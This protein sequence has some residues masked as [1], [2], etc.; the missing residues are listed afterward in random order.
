MVA[1]SMKKPGEIGRHIVACHISYKIT[2]KFTN[3]RPNIPF[4]SIF[5]EYNAEMTIISAI[6]MNGLSFS[7]IRVTFAA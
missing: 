4:Q 1:A 5:D 2:K 7:G 3:H 6:E